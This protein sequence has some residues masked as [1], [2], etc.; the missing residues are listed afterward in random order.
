MCE[1]EDGSMDVCFANLC[2]PAEI[3][4]PEGT[5]IGWINC[6]ENGVKTVRSR[7]WEDNDPSR[8]DFIIKVLGIDENKNLDSLERN[9]YGKLDKRVCG[10]I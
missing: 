4:L 5:T 3:K 1:V 10:Y 7:K 6:T 8:L 2:A 9:V